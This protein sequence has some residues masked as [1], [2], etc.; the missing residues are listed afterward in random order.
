VARRL[1]EQPEKLGTVEEVFLLQTLRQ[2]LA[3][4][5]DIDSQ[6]A[7]RAQ[8]YKIFLKKRAFLQ[9]IVTFAENINQ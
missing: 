8:K 1:L 2:I 4:G 9:E 7:H 5:I 3:A 6:F